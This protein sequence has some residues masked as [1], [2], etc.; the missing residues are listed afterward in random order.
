MLYL[1]WR[2][3]RSLHGATCAITS[4]GEWG[5]CYSHVHAGTFP[6]VCCAALFGNMFA[7]AKGERSI[8][9]MGSLQAGTE[10][11][12]FLHWGSQKWIGSYPLG[13]G[14]G[15][16]ATQGNQQVLNMCSSP[17]DPF[18]VP[19]SRTPAPQMFGPDLN[20]FLHCAVEENMCN[21]QASKPCLTKPSLSAMP[22]FCES[23]P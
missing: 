22:Y 3:C 20:Q 19:L 9:P 18:L 17:R 21:Q 23:K 8:L 12:S 1:P 7:E 14:G 13:A 10:I 5:M 4:S 2:A 6:T 11:N 16:A 15:W